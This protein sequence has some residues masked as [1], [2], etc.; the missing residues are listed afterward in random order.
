M[1]DEPSVKGGSVSLTPSVMG[2]LLAAADSEVIRSLRQWQPP[3][4]DELRKALPDYEISHLLGRGGMGAVYQ[5]CQPHLQ[6]TVAIKVL[7]AQLEADDLQYTARFRQEAQV[8][9]SLNHPHIVN[10]YESGETADGLLYFVMEYLDGVDVA[11]LIAREGKLD[12]ATALNITLAVCEALSAAHACGV[13]HRD[14]K[15]SNIMM[16][17]AGRVKVLDFGLAKLITENAHQFSG[18]LLGLGTPGYAA[19]EMHSR[20][21]QVDQRADIYGLG[22]TLY[23]MLTGRVPQGVLSWPAATDHGLEARCWPVIAK[24]LQADPQLRYPTA[25]LLAEDVKALLRKPSRQRLRKGLFLALLLPLFLVGYFLKSL[26]DSPPSAGSPAISKRP[27]MVSEMD[28]GEG[29]LLAPGTPK[30]SPDGWH[31]LLLEKPE[32]VSLFKISH[33]GEGWYN[34]GSGFAPLVKEEHAA[35]R[36]RARIMHPLAGRLVLLSRWNEDHPHKLTL[37][38]HPSG[39]KLPQ[40]YQNEP[41]TALLDRA[42][43]GYQVNCATRF[44]SDLLFEGWVSTTQRINGKISPKGFMPSAMITLGPSGKKDYEIELQSF[45]DQLRVLIDGKL[46]QSV[47]GVTLPHGWLAINTQGGNEIKCLEWR[48]LTPQG[49]PR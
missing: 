27:V 38:P 17:H 33:I 42:W 2:Q 8:M 7:P 34:I 6:R 19:P 39:K 46:I 36:L 15:P 30:V 43:F 25:S 48:P 20:D 29:P 37:Y 26:L 22:A 45:S 5:G 14:I 32:L 1:P 23:Q 21:I 28:A 24:A 10:V 35:L 49:Q 9:A 12:F 44:G 3:Q 47:S 11:R 31:S 13:I 16:D 40:Q 18:I 41:T 4:V